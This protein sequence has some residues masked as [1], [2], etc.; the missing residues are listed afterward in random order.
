MEGVNDGMDAKRLSPPPLSARGPL[1]IPPPTPS[2]I[3]PGELE[4][5]WSAEEDLVNWS[6][7]L[8]PESSKWW[9]W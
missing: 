9:S 4:M 2:P 8:N 1:P 3:P 6:F 7:V 5:V